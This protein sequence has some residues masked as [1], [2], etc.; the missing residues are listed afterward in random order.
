M[1]GEL[2]VTMVV[3][4]TINAVLIMGMFCLLGRYG[5]LAGVQIPE[6]LTKNK[7]DQVSDDASK[8]IGSRSEHANAELLKGDVLI[9]GSTRSLVTIR[10]MP[11]GVFDVVVSSPSFAQMPS[12][13]WTHRQRW[14][15]QWGDN[16]MVV[17]FGNATLLHGWANL[18]VADSLQD[19]EEPLPTLTEA[20]TEAMEF[21]TAST[22]A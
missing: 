8:A 14:R 5:F 4:L 18:Y 10:P 22:A 11:A 19:Q 17:V 16:S 7:D 13:W 9:S 2:I 12:D 3:V 6:W 20:E 21:P 15:G 1:G